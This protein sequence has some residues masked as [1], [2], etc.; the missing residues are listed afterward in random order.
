MVSISPDRVELATQ[1]FN[2]EVFFAATPVAAESQRESEC[3]ALKRRINTKPNDISLSGRSKYGFRSR[4]ESRTQASSIARCWQAP[5][6]IQ[7]AQLGNVRLVIAPENALVSNKFCQP[8]CAN[9][10]KVQRNAPERVRRQTDLNIARCVAM[11]TIAKQFGENIVT[12]SRASFFMSTPASRR[13][14]LADGHAL[15]AL[16]HAGRVVPIIGIMTVSSPP[17]CGAPRRWRFRAA[18]PTRRAG[19]CQTR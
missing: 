1:T 11:K 12:P 14:Y 8:Q 6:L 2:V 4:R 10:A 13:R 19:I 5:S 3:E 9:N 16:H 17:Y 18:S 7:C 15:H